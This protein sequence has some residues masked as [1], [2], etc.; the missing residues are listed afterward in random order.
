MPDLVK[1]IDPNLLILLVILLGGYFIW[2]VKTGIQDIKHLIRELIED[3]NSHESRLTRIESRC[4]MH[5]GHSR[6]SDEEEELY[7][8]KKINLV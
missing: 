5:H 7:Q 1:N 3:R 6:I 2:S 8:H 4:G